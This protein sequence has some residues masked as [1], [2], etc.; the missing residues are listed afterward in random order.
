MRTAANV[1]LFLLTVLSL[2]LGVLAG[3]VAL[4]SLLT[5]TAARIAAAAGDRFAR[6]FR[7][8]PFTS[9]LRDEIA[10]MLASKEAR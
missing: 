3:T 10:A 5:E 7:V 4:A 1:C 8:T 6:R 2:S 9:G